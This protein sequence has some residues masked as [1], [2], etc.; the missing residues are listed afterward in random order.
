VRSGRQSAVYIQIRL[1]GQGVLVELDTCRL[2]QG[3]QSI[4]I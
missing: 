1:I 2:R 3:E 4:A